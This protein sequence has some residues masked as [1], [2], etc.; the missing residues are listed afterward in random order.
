MSLT[1]SESESCASIKV[2]KTHT[3]T[4]AIIYALYLPKLNSTGQ[5]GDL[6]SPFTD[7]TQKL[8]SGSDVNALYPMWRQI[9]FQIYRTGSVQAII[10][11]LALYYLV[12]MFCV[13]TV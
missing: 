8:S 1:F 2:L 10:S 11:R 13:Q 4:Q 5:L 3:L 6:V 7:S 9:Q 12:A